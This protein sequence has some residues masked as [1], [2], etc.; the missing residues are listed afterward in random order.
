MTIDVVYTVTQIVIARSLLCLWKRNAL[1]RAASGT[2]GAPACKSSRAFRREG[3]RVPRYGTPLPYHSLSMR[4]TRALYLFIGTYYGQ[5]R[6]QTRNARPY[7]T[8][9]V[10]NTDVWKHARRACATR[11]AVLAKRNRG[12]PGMPERLSLLASPPATDLTRFCYK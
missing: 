9:A 5:S 2:G 6:T 4:H 1:D 11:Y 12:E 10:R 3:W 8:S 7:R